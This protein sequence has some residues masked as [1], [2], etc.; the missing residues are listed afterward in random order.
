[1]DNI[2]IEATERTPEV[3]FAFDENVFALRGEA[4]PE[5]VNDFFGPLIDQLDGHMTSLDGADI[6][7]NFELIY[8][9]SSTAKILMMLFE[10]L[11][12][13]AEKGNQVTVNWIY[14]ADDD[15]MEELGE[16]YGEDLEHAAFNLVAQDN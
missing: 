1:M 9:N 11:D 10:L 3:D 14:E 7:F 5:D 13:T 16:E 15:N 2:R 12:S 4:Y 8:F 6:T